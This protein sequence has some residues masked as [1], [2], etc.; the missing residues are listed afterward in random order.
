MLWVTCLKEAGDFHQVRIQ[1]DLAYAL[2]R[3][4][5]EGLSFLTIT[6]PAF[7]KDLLQSISLGS[8]GSDHFP[9]FR[10]SG[11]LPRFLS[12]FLHRIFDRTGKLMSQ[13]DPSVLRSLRQILLL[14]SKVEL[15]TSERRDVLALRQYIE[16]DASLPELS[17]LMREFSA[18]SRHLLGDY[19]NTVERR[20]QSFSWTPRHSGGAL[21]TRESFNSRYANVT[22]TER[23]QSVLPWWDD[24]VFS[25]RQIVDEGHKVKVLERYREIPVRVTTVPK[26]MKGPRI[27]AMEPCWMQFVQQGVLHAMT[28]VLTEERYSLESGTFSWMDQTPNRDLARVGSIDGSYAT[29]DL[30]EASDRVSLQLAESVLSAAPFLKEIVLAARSETAR[31]PSGLVFRLRKFASMG[32]ALCFPIESMVFFIIVSIAWADYRDIAPVNLRWGDLPPFRVFGDDL[33]VPKEVVPFLLA[34]L[35]L[36]GLK[37]NSRKSFTTGHF[38]E[39]C[40][41]DWYRGHDVSVFR[42]RRAFPAKRTSGELVESC[43]SFHNRAYSAGWF[44]TAAYVESLLEG[45]FGK[46]PHGPVG[47]SPCALW[48]WD[49]AKLSLRFSRTLHRWEIRAFVFRR[50]KPVDLLDGYGALRKVLTV[51]SER[52]SNHLERDG[53]SRCAGVHIGWSPLH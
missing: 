14:V 7:E 42:L 46:L 23:L 47:S 1:R 33:V 4:E 38:R 35:E 27:I 22:W 31:L 45:L 26:T 53:R 16:T 11:G 18:V 6:L 12:G 5:E 43:V 34:R 30:S 32:S 28:E 13:P 52:A 36:Y 15:P 24:M 17:P 21:A 50:T 25:P 9:G 19:L 29:I 39:S 41:S 40:G 37:V 8:I 49:R 3:V 51:R 48:T 10:R 44:E 20:I 2:S